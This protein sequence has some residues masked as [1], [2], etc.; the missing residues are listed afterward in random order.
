M[1]A[2]GIDSRRPSERISERIPMVMLWGVHLRSPPGKSRGI[3]LSP[4]P[5]LPIFL[6]VRVPPR[7]GSSGGEPTRNLLPEKCDS[8]VLE[9]CGEVV[10]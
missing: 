8:E 6:T 7:C 5:M 2:G 10:N 3:A 9:C 4:A 1:A